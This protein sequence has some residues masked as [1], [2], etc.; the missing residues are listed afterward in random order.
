MSINVVVWRFEHLACS[1]IR[2]TQT[3]AAFVPPST[4]RNL[5]T[6]A[7]FHT[8]LINEMLWVQGYFEACLRAWRRAILQSLPQRSSFRSP[9][10]ETAALLGLP[11]IVSA[12]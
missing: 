8:L 11:P 12:N 7:S 2:P 1:P 6:H 10:V 4:C 9:H 3:L 5:G